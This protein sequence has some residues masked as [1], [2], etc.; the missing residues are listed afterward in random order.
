MI[1]EYFVLLYILQFSEI[2]YNNF[3]ENLQNVCRV[4]VS[5]LA[6]VLPCLCDSDRIQP[7]L[8]SLSAPLAHIHYVTFLKVPAHLYLSLSFPLC[9]LLLLFPSLSPRFFSPLSC[10]SCLQRPVFPLHFALFMIPFPPA[11]HPKLKKPSA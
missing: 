1:F 3:Y 9:L 11:P 5:I 10:C 8:Q 4:P 7:Q 2:I 6:S